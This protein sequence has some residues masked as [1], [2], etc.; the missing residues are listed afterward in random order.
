MIYECISYTIIVIKYILQIN[1][2]FANFYE[3]T[4]LY[5]LPIIFPSFKMSK[6]ITSDKLHACYPFNFF[7]KFS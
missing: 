3:H 6:P 4:T 2:I 1:K 5:T 7:K